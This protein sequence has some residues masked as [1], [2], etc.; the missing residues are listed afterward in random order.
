[1]LIGYDPS[2]GNV[3]KFAIRDPLLLSILEQ[4]YKRAPVATDFVDQPLESAWVDDDALPEG[5]SV[6]EY[7]YDGGKIFRR[8][9][10]PVKA[11]VVELKDPR[12]GKMTTGIRKLVISK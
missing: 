4:K 6:S 8:A 3:I 12:T 1:M 11:E 9:L 2:D 7:R 5:E 10:Q